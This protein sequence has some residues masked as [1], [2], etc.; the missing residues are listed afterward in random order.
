MVCFASLKGSY[1]KEQTYS[2]KN[3]K[4]CYYKRRLFT[5]LRTS[6]YNGNESDCSE[7]VILFLSNG[8]K[9]IYFEYIVLDS[10]YCFRGGSRQKKR[11]RKRKRKKDGDVEIISSKRFV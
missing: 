6:F 2:L 7:R 9:Y 1:S 4:C 10:A 8:C 3:I 5:Y 11:E